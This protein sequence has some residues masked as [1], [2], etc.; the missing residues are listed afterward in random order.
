[1]RA[2]IALYLQQFK[3]TFAMMLQY[4]AELIIWMI[5]HVLE[6]LDIILVL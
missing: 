5:G 1:M 2:L 3:T 6:P 4:R